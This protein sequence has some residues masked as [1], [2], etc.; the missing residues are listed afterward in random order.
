VKKFFNLYRT[1]PL[2]A[3]ITAGL[4]C[5]VAAQAFGVCGFLPASI[6]SLF[7]YITADFILVKR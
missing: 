7:V 2:I 6:L 5:G 4:V 1:E 3:G